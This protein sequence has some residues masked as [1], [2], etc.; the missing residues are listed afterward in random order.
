V[1]A[2]AE[3]DARVVLSLEAFGFSNRCSSEEDFNQPDRAVQL[4]DPPYRIDTLTSIEGAKFDAAGKRR[5]VIPLDGVDVPFIG[6][7]ELLKIKRGAGRPQDTADV[8]RLS[9]H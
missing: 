7:H 2:N 4:A 9:G 8:E 3:H 5:V 6:R 1:W